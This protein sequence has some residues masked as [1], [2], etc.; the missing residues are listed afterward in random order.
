MALLSDKKLLE[1]MDWCYTELYANSIP[2][3][4]FSE[5]MDKFKINSQQFF[6]NH[7]I[8]ASDMDKIIKDAIK[9]FK[10]KSEWQKGMFSRSIYLGCSPKIR[11]ED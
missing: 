8:L 2:P 10:I 4:V 1:A 5:L 11:K 3:A 9:K 7:T 6:Q